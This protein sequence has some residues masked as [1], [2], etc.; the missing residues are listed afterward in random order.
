MNKG[1]EEGGKAGTVNSKNIGLH[2]HLHG[3]HTAP[4]GKVGA[5]LL[6]LII[7]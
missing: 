5:G 7:N 1:R 3:S 6:G 2:F 4:P